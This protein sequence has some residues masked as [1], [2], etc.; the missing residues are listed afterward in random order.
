MTTGKTVALTRRTFVDNVM[1]P[2]FNML[3][4]LEVSGKGLDVG[5][6]MVTHWFLFLT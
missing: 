6:K 1:S 4:R 5:G 3:S 2:L